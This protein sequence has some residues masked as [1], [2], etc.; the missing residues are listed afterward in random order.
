MHLW[1][2]H[3]VL[4]HRRYLSD[5]DTREGRETLL[6]C[7]PFGANEAREVLQTQ[8]ADQVDLVAAG[9]HEGYAPLGGLY[10]QC[11]PLVPHLYGT[12]EEQEKRRP[13]GISGS[14]ASPQGSPV[15]FESDMLFFFCRVMAELSFLLRPKL[16]LFHLTTRA[17]LRMPIHVDAPMRRTGGTSLLRLIHSSCPRTLLE[18][19][20]LGCTR[21]GPPPLDFRFIGSRP[22]KLLQSLLSLH[23]NGTTQLWDMSAFMLWFFHNLLVYLCPFQF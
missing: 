13:V 17:I 18:P 9:G 1:H 2:I 4:Y 21:E 23:I 8:R 7:F 3:L 15:R 19:L 14:A 10:T 20:P 16:P 22:F 5:A 12:I 6:C 11:P